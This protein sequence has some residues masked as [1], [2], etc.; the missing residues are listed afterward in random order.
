MEPK[1]LEYRDVAIYNTI[2]DKTKKTSFDD[3]NGLISEVNIV[4][5]MRTADN[6]SFYYFSNENER[7]QS[8][9]IEIPLERFNWIDCTGKMR[10][11][12]R[13][14]T[15]L[16]LCIWNSTAAINDGIF[17]NDRTLSHSRAVEWWLQILMRCNEMKK[18]EKEITNL[19]V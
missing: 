6:R 5:S 11:F 10:G 4:E 17:T 14:Q 18:H 3:S 9:S 1:A 2:D 7:N 13:R 19:L 8:S 12:T 16:C 15:I